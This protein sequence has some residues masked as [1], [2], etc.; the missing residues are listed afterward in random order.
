[1]KILVTGGAGFIGS[2]IVDRYI[3]AGHKVVV[4]DNLSTGNKKF[5]NKKAKFYKIDIT[6][7]AL[8]NVFR[9]EK[10]DI[11]NHHAAQIDIRKSVSDPIFDAN[12]NILGSLNIIKNCVD[13]SV[14]KIIFAS[15]GGAV[16]G[17]PEYMP[18][19]ETHRVRPLSPYGVAKLTIENYLVAVNQYSKLNFTILRYANVYGPRQNSMGEA[20]VCSIFVGKMKN[21]EACILYGYGNPVRDYVYV[22]DIARANILALTKGTGGIYNLGTGVGT[23]VKDIF[24]MLKKITGYKKQPKYKAL[25]PG[26]LQKTY[27]NCAR[28][29]KE[30]GWSPKVSLMEGLQQSVLT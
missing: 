16:Y 14:K 15:S 2:H 10:P 28:A 12:V 23:P 27:L 11:V 9:K 25:R 4:I 3:S 20:G 22:G 18:V 17:E 13:Y 1:M 21:N 29:K 30:L 6:D 24:Q 5:I 26:E 7:S 8:K 19:P